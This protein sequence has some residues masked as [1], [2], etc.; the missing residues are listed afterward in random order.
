MGQ[1]DKDDNDWRE[2]LDDLSQK[3]LLVHGLMEGRCAGFSAATVVVGRGARGNQ[4]LR[5]F[6]ASAGREDIKNADDESQPE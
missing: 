5:D 2:N 4:R 1:V 6:L 3:S